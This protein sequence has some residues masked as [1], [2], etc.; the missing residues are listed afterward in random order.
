MEL[1]AVAEG[2]HASNPLAIEGEKTEAKVT[3]GNGSTRPP[4]PSR[5]SAPTRPPPVSSKPNL[6][7]SIAPPTQVKYM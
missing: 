6:Q 3:D 2:Y 1:E 7:Y 4:R 5:P